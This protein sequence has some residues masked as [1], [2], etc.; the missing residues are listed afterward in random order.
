[1]KFKTKKFKRVIKYLFR[2]ER[3]IPSTIMNKQKKRDKL[4]FEKTN[5]TLLI[6]CT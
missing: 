3:R 4:K 2:I 5:I 1:M 6:P